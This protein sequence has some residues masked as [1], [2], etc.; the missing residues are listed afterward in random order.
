M[1]SL[2]WWRDVFEK[3]VLSQIGMDDFYPDQCPRVVV[4]EYDR[5]ACEFA[6]TVIAGHLAKINIDGPGIRIYVVEVTYCGP[7]KKV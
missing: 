6:T 2:H 1:V 3:H 7:N 4:V 5:S